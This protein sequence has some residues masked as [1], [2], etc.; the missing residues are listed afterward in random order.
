MNTRRRSAFN[1]AKAGRQTV[2]GAERKGAWCVSHPISL[3]KSS[4]YLRQINEEEEEDASRGVTKTSEKDGRA[5][6]KGH[7]TI[8]KGVLMTLL[9]E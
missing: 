6:E 2:E 8:L 4:M 7:E 3:H 5:M 1:A 9:R